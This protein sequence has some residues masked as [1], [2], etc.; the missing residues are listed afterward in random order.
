MENPTTLRNQGNTSEKTSMSNAPG[1]N[2]A[3]YHVQ[4]YFWQSAKIV[5]GR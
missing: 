4:L 2:N 3:H 5:G 1:C